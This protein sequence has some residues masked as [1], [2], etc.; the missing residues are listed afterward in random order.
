MGRSAQFL[1]LLGCSLLFGTA[2]GLCDTVPSAGALAA[3]NCLGPQG[4]ADI[5]AP[6]LPGVVNVSIIKKVT[7]Y[8]LDFGQGMGGPGG[9]NPLEDLFK[10]RDFLEQFELA[11]RKR[12]VPAG[13]GSGFIID[14][15]GYIVTNAHVVDGADEIIVT[16]SDQSELKAK[17]IGTDARTDMALLKVDSLKPL[18]ALKWGDSAKMRVGDWSIAIGNPLG[19]GG[20]VTLGIISHVA[21]SLSMQTSHIGG[22]LQT[23]APINLGNSGGPLFNIEGKVI[24]INMM[25]A[26]PTGG[27]VGI[28]FAIPSDVAQF[29]IH[30]LKEYGKVKRGWIGV[31]IQPI[32][33]E[34]AKSLG[35]AAPR[36]ALVGNVIE[37]GPAATAGVRQGDVLLKVGDV[38]VELAPNLT[39]IISS[40]P[41]GSKIQVGI[42][43]KDKG[44]GRYGEIILPIVIG[45]FQDQDEESQ[46]QENKEA[47]VN[48]E[49]A[50]VVYGVTLQELNS[51]LRYKFNLG[52][53]IS[54]LIVVKV[55]PESR[56]ADRFQ[57][58]D[59]LLEVDQQKIAS[60]KD[61]QEIVQ[62]TKAAGQTT[63]LCLVQRGGIPS[64]VPLSLE[65][66]GESVS[67]SQKSSKPKNEAL[68]GLMP[69]RPAAQG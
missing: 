35:L 37:K 44:T 38:P 28:G 43:R 21:R 45:E 25:L 3:V 24:G 68:G 29:V 17:I 1:A 42:W 27:N 52:D 20:S 31:Q 46:S 13:A 32:N 16:L 58:G 5:V 63:L 60:V 22:F 51:S 7:T 59:V 62:K 57:A 15:S 47:A 54:G 67:A 12:R 53:Q 48:Q 11:P 64:F 2:L 19:L 55:D 69:R 10:F 41:I 14:P 8:N 36:G 23:D 39:K 61:I 33:Q 4:F 65:E 18:V 30:Q 66:I 49:R 6:L 9:G 26:S 50:T 34:I 56:A 40:L